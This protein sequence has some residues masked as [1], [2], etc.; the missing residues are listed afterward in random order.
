VDV[1]SVVIVG[2]FV[3]KVVEQSGG[4][5]GGFPVCVCVWGN[6]I[7]ATTSAEINVEAPTAETVSP[8]RWFVT[9][10]CETVGSAI[11]DIYY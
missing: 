8:L 6:L 11:Y 2:H 10:L 1:A 4:N 9:S 7:A 3:A 5:D